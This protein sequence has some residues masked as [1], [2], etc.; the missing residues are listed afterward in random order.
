MKT[1][2]T[3]IVS[4]S[5]GRTSAYM[6][7]WL[8]Q[9]MSHLY[10]FI[11]VYA[12][13]G[14]EHQKTL[15]FV[16]NVDR[17]LNLNLVWL[18]AVVSIEKGKGTRHK[19]VDFYSACRDGEVFEEMIKKYG[20]PNQTYMHCTRELKLNPIASYKA[21]VG[22]KDNREAIGIRFDE[23][24]RVK[25]N[26]RLIYPLATIG[27]ITK[28][29]VLKFWKKQPFDLDLPE[30]L[31]N[32]VGCFKKSNVKLDLI[33]KTE[34]QYFEF[35]IDMENKYFNVITENETTQ[36]FIYRG[37]KTAKQIQDEGADVDNDIEEC[38]EECGS[39]ISEYA[40]QEAC[41]NLFVEK[42]V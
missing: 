31:G 28:Q 4:F 14:L 17:F 24:Q 27:K 3:I 9:N 18:E 34:P 8:Q 25:N 10:D 16:H 40:S 41:G 39:V 1:K 19:I 29:D 26:P 7:W 33:A 22:L 23:F 36:R 13:T 15:E 42:E 12:N 11:Y 6:C 5:G 30:Y 32:C 37:Y 2:E 20:L 21:S 35:F 38:P